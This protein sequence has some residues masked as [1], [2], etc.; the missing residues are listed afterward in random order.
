MSVDHRSHVIDV[1]LEVCFQED[2]SKWDE[3]ERGFLDPSERTYRE[4]KL[5]GGS[6]T[7]LFPTTINSSEP[8]Y[9]NSFKEKVR[10]V[11]L[12][13]FFRSE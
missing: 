6:N 10:V 5:M 9:F 1:N 8:K 11:V 12:V 13:H 4:K 3:I 7:L 2:L